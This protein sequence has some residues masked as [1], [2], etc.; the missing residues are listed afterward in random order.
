MCSYLTI[1]AAIS[2]ATVLWLVLLTQ[3]RVNLQTP[4]ACLSGG[5]RCTLAVCYAGLGRFGEEHAA[6][7]CLLCQ[8][9]TKVNVAPLS[10]G[11]QTR[12]YDRSRDT[13]HATR[14]TNRFHICN[15]EEFNHIN[16]RRAVTCDCLASCP[17]HDPARP[18]RPF[19]TTLRPST[20]WP[21]C[22]PPLLP[23]SFE[24]R[25]WTKA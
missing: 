16:A 20:M 4:E 2:P 8:V 3:W 11:H 23:S 5:R 14:A 18:M 17:F 12:H 15:G 6:S 19:S 25:Q 21:F 10:L 13:L 1:W 24:G 22:S 9:P 7:R